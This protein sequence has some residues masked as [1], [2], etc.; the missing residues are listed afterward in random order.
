[1]L[2]DRFF[3]NPS[4]NIT[5]VYSM[6]LHLPQFSC[7]KMPSEYPLSFRHKQFSEN[8]NGFKLVKGDGFLK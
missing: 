4:E 5:F 2:K 1:M 8:T 6:I 7:Y 3:I